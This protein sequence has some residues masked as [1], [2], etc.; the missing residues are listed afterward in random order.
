MWARQHLAFTTRTQ[1]SPQEI[2]AL[3]CF[4]LSILT[5]PQSKSSL[6]LSFWFFQATQGLSEEPGTGQRLS[7]L[8]VT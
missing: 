8:H 3:A 7:C 4:P 5:M 6:S 1:S 2:S